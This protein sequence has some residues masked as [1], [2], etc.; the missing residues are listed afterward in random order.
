MENRDWKD[1]VY[2][3][4]GTEIQKKAYNTLK[5]HR[6]LE[7]LS[8]FDPVLVSTVCV[9]LDIDGSD[10]DIICQFKNLDSFRTFVYKRFKGY[11]N[12]K[13]WARKSKHEELVTSFFADEFEIE[14]FGSKT[15]VEK[16]H[17]YRHLSMMERALKIGGE[18]LRQKVIRLKK[19]GIKTE[20]SFAKILGLEGDPYLSFL[21]LEKLDDN[22]LQTMI[23]KRV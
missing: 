16:Q 15:A 11:P 22:Q 13:Q 3:C 18:D 7:H 23:G 6:I 17:G 10:L 14:I 19:T 8:R 5:K 4:T 20:P 12:F 2:L 21:K 9:N 1:I